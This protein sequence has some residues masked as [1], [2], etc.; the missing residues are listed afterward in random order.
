M[1]A[2]ACM[3]QFF[4]TTENVNQCN[5][6]SSPCYFYFNPGLCTELES[7]SCSDG[8]ENCVLGHILDKDLG[9]L[10]ITD[11]VMLSY[12]YLL[13]YFLM[14]PIYPLLLNPSWNNN[15]KNHK[16]HKNH[17]VHLVEAQVHGASHQAEHRVMV[18]TYCPM[19][20]VF[21]WMKAFTQHKCKLK[22]ARPS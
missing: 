20:D 18:F 16:N 2:N 17:L 13:V 7:V 3:W 14:F 6:V 10:F 8:L 5:F 11:L 15:N 19:T 12:V 22:P 9:L 1:R 21:P 4:A